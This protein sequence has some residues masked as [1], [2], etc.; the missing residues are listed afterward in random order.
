MPTYRPLFFRNPRLIPAMLFSAGLGVAGYYGMQWR[1]LPRL[2]E[3]ELEQSTE[4]N[5]AL[6]LARMTPEQRPQGQ[7]LEEMKAR[8]RA[9]V[10][11]DLD[12]ERDTIH[13]RF[14]AGLV[15]MVFGFGQLVFVYL[16]E[17]ARRTK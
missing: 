12:G 7:Q 13:Q 4:L 9:E 6:D 10:L 8:E 17:R 3:Q 11:T 5:L 14:A 1:D 16:N 15:A 2:T